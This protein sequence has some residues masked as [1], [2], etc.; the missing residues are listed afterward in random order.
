MMKMKRCLIVTG[1]TD[2][3]GAFSPKPNPL[4][5]CITEQAAL[6]RIF[7]LSKNRQD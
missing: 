5:T 7:Q 4:G 6:K 1:G 3:H 2:F